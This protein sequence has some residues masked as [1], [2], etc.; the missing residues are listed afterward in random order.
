M[1]CLALA[2]A[3]A[4]S[5]WRCGFACRAGTLETVPSLK[6]SGHESLELG[7]DPAD[8]AETMAAHWPAGCQLL[9]VDHYGRAAEF[10]GGCRPWAGRILIIDDLADR[11]HDCDFLLDPT[12][13]RWRGHYATLVPSHC[14]MLL[15]PAY[16]LLRPQF[17]AARSR[18]QP[19]ATEGPVRRILV[20]L[21][22]MDVNNATDRVLEAIAWA[23]I[24][25]VV[26]V[27][28]GAGAPHLGEVKSHAQEMGQRVTVHTRVEDMTALMARADLA[29]G[30]AGITSWER[31]CLGLPSVVVVTAG[32]QRRVAEALEREGAAV[33][34]GWHSAVGPERIAAAVM[35]LDRDSARRA[36]MGAK[37]AALCDG[38]GARR[39]GMEILS[40]ETARDG[41]PIRLRPAAMADAD[42]MLAW[43]QDPR[44]RRHFR[45][46]DT[47]TRNGHLQWL[48]AKLADPDCL[49]NIV[50][51]GGKP[52]G[53]L[54]LDRRGNAEVYEISILTAPD[55][56]RLGLASAALTLARQ[57]LPQACFEAEVLSNNEASHALFRGAGYMLSQG[58]YVREATTDQSQRRKSPWQVR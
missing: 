15:G 44:T 49:F 36:R 43:Q 57:L 40:N 53:V 54:R 47:P 8:E 2:D 9:V 25:A 51:H 28:L 30:A 39:V 12:P 31:C 5:A 33:S 6:V 22:T 50:L 38:R 21:G 29:I 16:A 42:V 23:G 34:L 13:G 32:N 56:R 4:T 1:R 41:R 11:H 58:R 14:E 3:L 17:V 26:D 10:E 35:E 20:S 27:V 18:L 24:D 52:A 46:P 7:C 48:A 37:A 19:R 55:R 45:N